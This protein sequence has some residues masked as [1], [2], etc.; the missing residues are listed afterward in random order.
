VNLQSLEF[1]ARA[2]VATMSGIA[3]GGL[4]NMQTGQSVAE[5]PMTNYDQLG[6]VL[7]KFNGLASAQAQLDVGRIVDLRDQLA[8]GRLSAPTPNYPLTLLKFGKPVKGTIPVLAKIALTDAWFTQQ[9]QFV[10][11]AMETIQTGLAEWSKNKK[12]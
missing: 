11:N 4:A 7:S 3:W 1:S 10:Y 5:D 12:T 8:H 2:A 6:T 9:R